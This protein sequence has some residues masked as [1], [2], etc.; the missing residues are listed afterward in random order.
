MPV[1]FRRARKVHARFTAQSKHILKW[2]DRKVSNGTE[3]GPNHGPMNRLILQ[4]QIGAGE[5]S[6]F[7]HVFG[8]ASAVMSTGTVPPSHSR[9]VVVRACVSCELSLIIMRAERW[10][11]RIFAEGELQ[12]RHSGKTESVADRFHLGSDHA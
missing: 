6:L 11:L 12:D 3:D 4:I 7:G 5:C 1:S 9:V 2:D 10:A 8:S